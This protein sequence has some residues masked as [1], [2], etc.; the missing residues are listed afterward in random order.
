MFAE[1]WRRYDPNES[2]AICI[3]AHAGAIAACEAHLQVGIPP[4]RAAN[5]GATPRMTT[6]NGGV[7]AVGQ[8]LV[9]ASGA[10]LRKAH[11]A[12]NERNQQDGDC[13]R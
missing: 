3:A 4:P 7:G 8:Y 10:R 5:A 13:D 6:V 12:R 1:D 2:V 9:E 11:A